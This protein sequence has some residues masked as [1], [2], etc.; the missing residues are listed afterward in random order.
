MEHLQMDFGDVRKWVDFV[1]DA[2]RKMGKKM[3]REE[4]G[5]ERYG[6]L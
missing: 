4:G 5:T 2:P 1:L 6:M 3:R